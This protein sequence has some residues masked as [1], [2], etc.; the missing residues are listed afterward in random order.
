MEYYERHLKIAKQVGDRAGEGIAN[1]NIGNTYRSLGN[2][3]KAV[4]CHESCLKIAKE[5]GD[6][7]TEGRAYGNLGSD[8][9]GL[10]DFK[11]AIGYNESCLEVSKE[12]GDRYGEGTTYCN[13]GNAYRCLGK[14]TKAIDYHERALNVAREIGNKNLEGRAYG[15]LG[16]AYFNLGD[17]IKSI[18]YQE[19][20]LEIARDVEDRSGEGSAYG[21]LGSTYKDL[22][23]FQ[24]AIVY[25]ERCLKIAKELNDRSEEGRACGN[26]GNTYRRLGDFQ[27]AME[28][29]ELNLKIAREVG[30][31]SEEGSAYSKLGSDYCDLG[32]FQK[33][34]EYHQQHLKICKDVG[35]SAQ[36]GHIYSK[37]GIA[38]FNL[39]DF[40]KAKTYFELD[41][42]IAKEVEDKVEEGGAYSNLGCCFELLGSHDEAFECYQSSVRVF[43]DVRSRLQ[44]KDTWKISLRDL[45]QNPY[46]AL[47][48]VLLKLG[49]S[50]DALCAAEKGRAQALRDLM[51]SRYGILIADVR[52]TPDEKAIHDLL[53]GIQC[54][55]IFPAFNRLQGVI[56]VWVIQNSKVICRRI[57]EDGDLR[58][59]DGVTRYIQSVIEDIFG[60]IGATAGV[61]CEDRSLD[62][63]RRPP[64]ANESSNQTRT[65]S[66]QSQ[67]QQLRR[68][69]DVMIAPITDLIDG[70][71]IIIVPEGPLWLA[72][73]AAFIDSQSKYLSES[74]RIRVIPSL[75]SLAL[76]LECPGDYHSKTGALLVGDPWVQEVFS[77]N[78]CQLPC[79]REEVEMIGRILNTTPLTGKEATKDEVMKRLSSVSLVHIAAHGRM[80]TGEIALCPNPSRASRKPTDDDF[81]LTMADVLEVKLRARLVVL[82]CCHSGRGE[83]KAEGVV[84]IARAFL[85]A[86]A[87]SVLVS[88][89]AIDDEATLEFMKHFYQHLKEGKSA[90]KALNQT[91]K[92]MRESVKFSEVKYWAPFVLVGDDVTL[93][94]DQSK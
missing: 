59:R 53:S 92:S 51:E 93:E 82:S 71:E 36:E 57:K 69:Y 52:S 68:L 60:A 7:A 10:G 22:G 75:T 80:D 72:P 64:L 42:K 46:T 88:L 9:H 74:F 18:N 13:L 29:H 70:D 19:R 94:F 37:L 41:L 90:S 76:I 45:N 2:F 55:T 62:K 77:Y 16:K 84:G 87:R 79:A 89:W 47:W 17:F 8:F 34:I 21:N 86:G 1:G 85:G 73:Y 14:Y 48:R 26:L 67:N 39:G 23:D 49:R 38:Y 27:K 44:Y 31:T 5:V 24:K 66:L 83:I 12:L 3:T 32:N 35:N 4:D 6:R 81:L 65:L 78:L 54:N 33:A 25:Q 30:D 28:F 63:L 11:K 20:C 43:D 40:E 56:N 50:M 58:R 61:D 15:N 91:M